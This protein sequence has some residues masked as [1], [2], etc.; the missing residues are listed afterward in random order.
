MYF[1]L[2]FLILLT[3]II[4]HVISEFRKKA[5]LTGESNLSITAKNILPASRTCKIC[6]LITFIGLIATGQLLFLEGSGSG[7][8][9]LQLNEAQWKNIH[10]ILFS[11]FIIAFGLHL[12]THSKWLKMVISKKL[13]SVRK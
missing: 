5:E 13:H 6:S 10:L 3:A 11:V 2:V 4:I 9:L 12:Y 8:S 7:W 1:L